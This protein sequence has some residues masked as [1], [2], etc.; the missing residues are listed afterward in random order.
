MIK[1]SIDFWPPL[2]CVHIC[3][4]TSAWTHACT[5]QI[6]KPRNEQ[7]KERPSA[8]TGDNVGL[9]FRP[10]AIHAGHKTPL[11]IY[12]VSI[13]LHLNTPLAFARVSYLITPQ[14]VNC[15][16]TFFCLLTLYDLLHTLNI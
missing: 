15:S 12:V 1:E 9:L 5:K 6:T 13:A 7:V 14:M 4:F 3:M 8:T 11:A 10:F 16:E 2:V